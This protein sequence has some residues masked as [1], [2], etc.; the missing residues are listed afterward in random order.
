MVKKIDVEFKK[1]RLYFDALEA[2][3]NGD[4]K[5]CLE[6]LKKISDIDKNFRNVGNIIKNVSNG[7]SMID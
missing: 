5:K 1:E 2:E 3:V 6:N 7:R 4:I